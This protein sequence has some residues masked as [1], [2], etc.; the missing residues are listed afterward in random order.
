FFE[1]QVDQERGAKSDSRRYRPLVFAKPFHEQRDENDRRD[2]DAE[3]RNGEAVDRG[4]N[5]DAHHLTKLTPFSEQVTVV[6]FHQKLNAIHDARQ[7]DD[8]ADVEGKEPGLR[9]F[10]APPESNLHAAYDRNRTK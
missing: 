9:A 8:D 6:G 2:V 1:E 10:R 4:R 5:D 7:D 3:I